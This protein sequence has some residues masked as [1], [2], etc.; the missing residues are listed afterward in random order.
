VSEKEILRYRSS[1]MNAD[2][3]VEEIFTGDGP[4]LLVYW[5]EGG[6]MDIV[7]RVPLGK[8]EFIVPIDDDVVKDRHILLPSGAEEYGKEEYLATDIDSLI[9]KYV[10]VD[11]DDRKLAIHSTQSSW[12][13]E[14]ATVYNYIH[15]MGDT[16]TGK[17]RL[18]EIL[19]RLYYHCLQSSASATAASMFRLVEK[20][21]PCSFACDEDEYLKGTTDTDRNLMMKALRAGTHQGAAIIRCDD[22][23]K[24]PIL[25]DCGCP[26]IFST[27]EPITDMALASRCLRIQMESTNRADIRRTLPKKFLDEAVMIQN[28]LLMYRLRKLSNTNMNLG[29]EPKI[30]EW[31]QRLLMK[32][33]DGHLLETLIPLSLVVL[34]K[35]EDWF[36]S[37]A[38]N[39][40]R[41]VWRE[42]MESWYGQIVRVLLKAY[43]EHGDEFYPGQVADIMNKNRPQEKQ[44]DSRSIGRVV[45]ALKIERKE[46]NRGMAIKISDEKIFRLLRRYGWLF[47]EGVNQELKDLELKIPNLTDTMR[48]YLSGVCGV[49]GETVEKGEGAER[50]EDKNLR[51][52]GD[53]ALSTETPQ[54]PQTPL[55]ASGQN[56]KPPKNTQNEEINGWWCYLCHPPTDQGSREGLRSHYRLTHGIEEIK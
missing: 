51:P 35:D 27:R 11:E 50:E 13:Q 10:D 1:F 7:D 26:K 56:E 3:I 49:S 16:E 32:G 30:A 17:T 38:Q 45:T 39:K 47:D 42:R 18:R 28:K 29:F 6:K 40:A 44:I 53:N 8:N 31:E 36:L 52:V 55:T 5:R 34:P 25:Y 22:E 23:N 9:K 15:P 2:I 33:I 43:I 19:A 4:R 48:K 24:N 41:E 46:T 20:W 12:L 54:T 37:V 21:R 14:L